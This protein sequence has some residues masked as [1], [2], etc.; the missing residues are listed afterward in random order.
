MGFIERKREK[1]IVARCLIEIAERRSTLRYF[2]KLLDI[3]SSV[4]INEIKSR[5]VQ[6]LNAIRIRKSW[7]T[8][9]H[10]LREAMTQYGQR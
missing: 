2:S 7:E 3:F 5:D 4:E 6:R 9:G 10:N 1:E 8:V